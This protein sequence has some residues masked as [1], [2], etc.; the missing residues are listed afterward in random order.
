MPLKISTSMPDVCFD[1]TSPLLSSSGYVS[2]LSEENAKKYLLTLSKSTI[3]LSPIPSSFIEGIRGNLFATILVPYRTLFTNNYLWWRSRFVTK[4]TNTFN[5]PFT[6]LFGDKVD[7]I[8]LGINERVLWIEEHRGLTDGIYEDFIYIKGDEYT[9]YYNDETI[10][11]RNGF[12][13]YHEVIEGGIFYDLYYDNDGC[14]IYAYVTRYRSLTYNIYFHNDSFIRLI[15]GELTYEPEY[16]L[17]DEMIY[18]IN[19]CLDNA[20]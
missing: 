9:D 14:L 5:P 17:N 18:A 15:I 13:K 12:E 2:P 10:I 1:I 7:E 8:I 16:I 4:S 3:L 11:L 19:L 6:P 20:Y